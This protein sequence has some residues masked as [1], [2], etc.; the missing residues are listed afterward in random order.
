[1]TADGARTVGSGSVEP[2]AREP[3]VL[4]VGSVNVDLVVRAERLPGPGETVT[5]GVFGRYGGGKGAN[6]AVAA[7]RDGADVRFVGAVG[8][9]ELGTGVVGELRA[10]AVDTSGLGQLADAA[11][12]VAVIVVDATGENQ[13]AV[14]PG[15]NAR[16]DAGA[17]DAVLDGVELPEGGALLTNFEIPSAG[18]VRAARRARDAGMHVVV[19]PAPARD[20][21]RELVELG[22]LLVPNAGEASRLSGLDN[23]ERAAVA[24]QAKTSA[25]V[26][27]TLGSEGA[28]LVDAEGVRRRPAFGAHVVDTTGAGDT[29]CGVLAAGLGRGL[30]LDGAVERASAA[31]ALSVGVSGARGGMPG[32][33]AIDALLEGSR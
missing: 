11:T 22:P 28:L 20:L 33:D 27:V 1:M 14:A 9:D 3:F 7:S 2:M 21:S 12:G 24:L 16:V 30:E 29:F 4:V 8:D 13:I 32:T 19:N 10:E 23:P 5:D 26:I 18:L 6:Q 31:A 15:A 25:P 17:V